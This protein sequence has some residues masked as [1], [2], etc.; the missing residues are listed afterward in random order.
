MLLALSNCESR[1]VSLG[2]EHIGSGPAVDPMY[3]IAAAKVG[4]RDL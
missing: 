2:A 1:D 4:E 3:V